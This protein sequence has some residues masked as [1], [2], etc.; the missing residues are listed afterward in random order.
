MNDVQNTTLRKKPLAS[1]ITYY[2]G[3]KNLLRHILPL[4]PPHT[5]Y[6]EPFAGGLA[7]FFAKEPAPVEIV[8]D[9]NRFVTNFY[10][11][12]Q[13]NFDALQARIQ[14]TLTSRC[15]YDDAMIMYAHSHMFSKLDWAWAFWTLTNQGYA[16]GIGSWGYSTSDSKREAS[17]HNKRVGFTDEVHQRLHKTQVENRDALYLIKMRDRPETFFYLDP[18]YY[19]SNM[20][21]YSG[22]TE[23]NFRALLEA[24]SQIKGKFLLSCYPSDLA[25][26]YIQKCGWHSIA[27]EQRVMASSNRKAKVEMLIANYPILPIA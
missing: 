9:T 1:P 6:C 16:S 14:A 12:V 24:A 21:H 26:E 13:F 5:T 19:N 7:V 15:A 20:G 8:N 2:G 18:P 3:K 23:H 11:Q 25:Q 10:E 17:M 22:Y 27:I 4:I